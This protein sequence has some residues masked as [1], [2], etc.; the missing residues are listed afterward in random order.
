[1]KKYILRYPIGVRN[2]PANLVLR[3]NLFVTWNKSRVILPLD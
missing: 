1:M 3:R 2:S